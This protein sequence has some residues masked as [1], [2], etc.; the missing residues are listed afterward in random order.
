MPCKARIDAPGALQHIILRGIDSGVIFK[1]NTDCENFLTRLERLL[2][3]SSTP[4]LAWVLMDNHVHMLLRTAR[5]PI[6]ILM[7]RLL[8]SYAQ[9]FNRRHRR[10]GVLFQNRYKYILCENQPYLLE[11]VRY[12][13]LNPLRAGVV[14]DMEALRGYPRCGHSALMGQV[15]RE[16]QDTEYALRLFGDGWS[17][18]RQSTIARA[19]GIR[20]D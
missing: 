5:L 3:E 13:H 11:L 12:I 15:R 19:R 2:T 17:T 6:S 4:C 8:T 1:D 16:W 20:R 9:Q 14:H 7:R 10:H 18:G